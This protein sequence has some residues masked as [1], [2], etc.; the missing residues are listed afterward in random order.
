MDRRHNNK[1]KG[2]GRTKGRKE[3]MNEWCLEEQKLKMQKTRRKNIAVNEI[4]V[5]DE[6]RTGE[7]REYRK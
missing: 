6:I 1:E 5:V 4:I 7:K 3:G 2:G